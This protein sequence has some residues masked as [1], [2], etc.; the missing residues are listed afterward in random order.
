MRH[1]LFNPQWTHDKPKF[2]V[3]GKVRDF[4]KYSAVVHLYGFNNPI[5][6]K[7]WSKTDIKNAENYV[8]NGGVILFIFDGTIGAKSNVVGAM[9]SLFGAKS[10][11][12]FSGKAEIKDPAW[13]DCGKIP[14]VFKKC[15]AA[16]NM[17]H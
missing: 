4:S 13:A 7:D 3:I 15:W 1:T 5:S 9:A 2:E 8:R 10:F 17:P 6:L 16:I 14:L 12:E 11:G